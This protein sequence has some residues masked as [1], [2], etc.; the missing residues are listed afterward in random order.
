M[1]CYRRCAVLGPL[2]VAVAL[3]A[4][5]GFRPLV[6]ADAD[7]LT[8][9]VHVEPVAGRAGYYLVSTLEQRI[10]TP[11]PDAE[12]VLSVDVETETRVVVIGPR[13]EILRYV[14]LLVADYKLRRAG[15]A[16]PI[17]EDSVEV[18]TSV[19][20]T[21]SPYAAFV[22]ERDRIRA[23]AI[24]AAQRIVRDMYV[25]LELGSS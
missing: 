10:G 21:E 22:A 7:A 3:L 11:G 25:Q 24:E 16:E 8:N 4:G 17:I 20:A 2:L 9:R 13:E 19:D 5:C 18:A 14:V 1:W 6:S 23:A 15:T 12:W